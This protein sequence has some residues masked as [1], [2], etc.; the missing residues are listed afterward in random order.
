MYPDDVRGL[1]GRVN[2]ALLPIGSVCMQAFYYG[3]KISNSAV[4]LMQDGLSLAYG[5]GTIHIEKLSP[6][7]YRSRIHLSGGNSSVVMVMVDEDIESECKGISGDLYKLDKYHCYIDEKSLVGYF[8]KRFDL[9]MDYSPV[10]PEVTKP[11][12]IVEKSSEVELAKIKDR[13]LIIENLQLTIQELKSR[14]DYEDTDEELDKLKTMLGEEREESNRLEGVL[15]ACQR[16]KSSLKDECQSIKSKYDSLKDEYSRVTKELE[17]GGLENKKQVNS[18]KINLS[19]LEEDVK[20]KNKEI[21]QLKRELQS[22]TANSGEVAE[23]EKRI[24]ELE[25]RIESDN[26][27]LETLNKE[28]LELLSRVR[29]LECTSK[30][31]DVDSS[32]KVAEL[33]RKLLD[34]SDNVFYRL[35]QSVFKKGSVPTLINKG[36]YNITFVFSGSTESRKGTYKNLYEKLKNDNKKV[37]LV[38]AT[39]ETFVDYVFAM[40]KVVDGREWFVRGGDLNRYLSPTSIDSVRVLSPGVGYVDDGFFLAVDW[41]K[42]LRDL[43][44]SGYSVILYCGDISSIVPRVLYKSFLGCGDCVVYVNGNTVGCRTVVSNLRGLG[45]DKRLVVAYYDYNPKLKRFY[46]IV[47]SMCKCTIVK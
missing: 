35:G 8:N 41:E 39:S 32:I 19:A 45:V 36:S 29:V 42:R 11:I 47:A 31:S 22:A 13:D 15:E 3:N 46:D 24:K 38:D 7:N 40:T 21:A 30:E 12:E 34:V 20:S 6:D 4:S 27:S 18:L 37:L 44:D 33:E 23:K 10:I 16:E 26:D 2:P 17:S 43:E 5:E 9:E 14:L 28:K 1:K 25:A